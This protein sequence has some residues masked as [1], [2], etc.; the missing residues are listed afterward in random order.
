[1]KNTMKFLAMLLAVVLMLGLCACGNGGGNTGGDTGNSG[2]SDTKKAV[3]LCKSDEAYL[4]E[5]GYTTFVYSSYLDSYASE[6][7]ADVAD[8]VRVTKAYNDDG[9]SMMVYYLKT[10]AQA[11]ACYEKDTSSYKLVGTRVVSGDPQG[12]IK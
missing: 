9:D 2:V 10:E 7:G 6:L 1:M 4:K 11:K 12:L 8:L 5:Q 3:E